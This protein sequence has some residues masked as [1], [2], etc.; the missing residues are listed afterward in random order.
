[1]SE[2]EQGG[3]GESE[4]GG[5]GKKEKKKEKVGRRWMDEWGG[6]GDSQP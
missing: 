5:E 1:M 4:G 6:G 3:E 2:D